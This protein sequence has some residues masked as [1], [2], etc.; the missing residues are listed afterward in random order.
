MNTL[1]SRVLRAQPLPGEAASPIAGPRI[2]DFN[3]LNFPH[4]IPQSQKIRGL[5]GKVN[6]EKLPPSL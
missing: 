3:F 4:D 5:G 2:R 1:A 6:K